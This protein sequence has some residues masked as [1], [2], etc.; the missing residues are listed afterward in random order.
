ML[1][2]SNQMGMGKDRTPGKKWF[3]RYTQIAPLKL[4]RKSFN[5]SKLDSFKS[6]LNEQTGVEEQ[7]KACIMSS[8]DL[9]DIVII[10]TKYPETMKLGLAFWLKR[11]LDVGMFEKSFSELIKD[12][13]SQDYA[14]EKLGR[15][16]SCIATKNNMSVDSTTQQLL[17]RVCKGAARITKMV[18]D[19]LNK[20]PIPKPGG[21][22]GF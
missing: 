4:R 10:P 15:I 2:R 11:P 8:L 13:N 16:M 1:F 14:C 6:S 20:L 9:K 7:V 17:D 5:E 12:N 18:T 21:F 19:V 22:P 3:D